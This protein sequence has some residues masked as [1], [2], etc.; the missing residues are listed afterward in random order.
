MSRHA[1]PREPGVFDATEAEPILREAASLGLAIAVHAD[2]MSDTG[3]AA[4]AARLDA[5][6]A[7]HVVRASTEGLRALERSGTV[8]VLL[9]GS[10]LFVGYQPPD[11]KRLIAHRV[12]VA[13]GTD[14]NPGTSPL[15]GMPTAIALA[16]ALCGLTPHEAIVAATAN[17][18]ADAAKY[19]TFLRGNEA[20]AIFAKYGF[21][22]LASVRAS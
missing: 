14:H 19:L 3:G 4:L 2:Q 9:P 20:R 7:D 16:V 10:S 15:E 5:R 21:S 11:A 18:K 13:L 17:A 8:A 22:V 6:S 12:P 1:L